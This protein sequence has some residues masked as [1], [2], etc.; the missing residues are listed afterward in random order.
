ML[1]APS[2]IASGSGSV[3]SA[4]LES[5]SLLSSDAVVLPTGQRVRPGG[6]VV[7][8]MAYP[9]GA[10]VSPDGRRILAIAGRVFQT[11]QSPS[12]PSVELR[13]IDAAS[14]AT[15]QALHV[16]DAF[17]SVSYSPNGAAVYVAG[18]SDNVVHAYAV[19][20][21]GLLQPAPDLAVPGCQFVSGLAVAPDG[22]ALWAV[23]SLSGTV[24]EVALPDGR[25]LR[26]ASL[27]NPDQVALS[28]DGRTAYV[29]DW[30]GEAV[31]AVGAMTSAVRTFTV[32]AEPEGLA[33][34]ANGRVVVADSN[35]AT[36]ATITPSTGAVE[37]TSLGIVGTGRGTDAPNDVVA[38][39]NGR[40]YVSLGAEN[41]VVVLAPRQDGSWRLAGLVP[42]AWDPT[43]VALGPGGRRLEVVAG[44]G[45]GHSAGATVPYVS[46]D[47]S[48]LAPDGA[49]LTVGTLESLTTPTGT[50][51][52]ADTAEVRRETA[53]WKPAGALPAVLG[54]HSPIHHIIYVTRENKTYDSELGDLHPSPGTALATFGATVTPNMHLIATRYADAT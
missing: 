2:S 28:P 43:A 5:A 41:A 21:A 40:V 54:P 46:P 51:L 26:Q 35:D 9:T 13:V 16:G 23:C 27:A 37:F 4:S 19:N 42:T 47:P 53:A 11:A 14:G 30:R 17:Q 24:A 38:A 6:R 25:V 33:V 32:G 44:L 20:A 7:P 22:S 48:A 10:A 31:Y 8:L 1:V 15:L 34:L 52:A 49:Y 50:A 18:G 36:L 45:L 3:R 29:T 39:P 12:G